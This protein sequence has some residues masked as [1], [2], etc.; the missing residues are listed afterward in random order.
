VPREVG[1]TT[2]EY[3]ESA[4]RGELD[5]FYCI[6]GN[7]LETMPEPQRIAR[8]LSRIGLRV[9][10]DIVLTKQM[11]VRATNIAAA[12]PRPRPSGA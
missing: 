6:G 8:A 10:S 12:G 5:A 7:F 11:L 3:L 9:H 1:A 2:V 4:L